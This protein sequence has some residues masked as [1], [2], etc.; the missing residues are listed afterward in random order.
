MFQWC[1]LL[2]TWTALPPLRSLTPSMGLSN[3][4]VKL[5]SPA[6]LNKL[7]FYASCCTWLPDPVHLYVLLFRGALVY[8]PLWIVIVIYKY[9][10]NILYC[11]DYWN[12]SISTDCPMPPINIPVI[13]VPVLWLMWM[14]SSR[15]L[16]LVVWNLFFRLQHVSSNQLKWQPHLLTTWYYVTSMEL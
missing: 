6:K 14:L 7:I 4:V 9:V 16:K 11:S 10:F 1:A 2:P 5:M 3:I 8:W 13:R 12:V 15:R